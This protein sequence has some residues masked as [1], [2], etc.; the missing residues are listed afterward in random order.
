MNAARPKKDREEH[1]QQ[2]KTNTGSHV[3]LKIEFNTRHA[4]I[5]KAYII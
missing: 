2:E 1:E 4:F 5:N 3:N